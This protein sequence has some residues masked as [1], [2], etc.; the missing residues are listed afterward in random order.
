MITLLQRE[1][2]PPLRVQHGRLQREVHG[3]TAAGGPKP[4]CQL[5]RCEFREQLRRSAHGAY[6]L[7]TAKFDALRPSW[8][9]DCDQSSLRAE[10]QRQAMLSAISAAPRETGVSERCKGHLSAI[11]AECP[12]EEQFFSFPSSELFPVN[13]TRGRL[14]SH[15]R[16]AQGWC[17][18]PF[19]CGVIPNARLRVRPKSKPTPPRGNR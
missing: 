9:I 2:L 6:R 13:P 16:L 7:Q 3:F 15:G 1:K 11:Q 4:F 10:A 8:A 17:W 19:R 18:F 5:P 12:S 14:R